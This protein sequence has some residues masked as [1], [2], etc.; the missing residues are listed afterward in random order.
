MRAIGILSQNALGFDIRESW[1]AILVKLFYKSF[2]S[3][4]NVWDIAQ[5]ETV[6]SG[7]IRFG[8]IE[9]SQN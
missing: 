5:S 2:L 9:D 7:T 8:K 3:E 4:T 1:T 6:A